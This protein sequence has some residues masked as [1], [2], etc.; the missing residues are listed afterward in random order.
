MSLKLL[1]NF[2]HFHVS[3]YRVEIYN[4]LKHEIYKDRKIPMLGVFLPH[5]QKGGDVVT[6]IQ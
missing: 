3:D 5:H 2:S 4:P 1:N 6:F